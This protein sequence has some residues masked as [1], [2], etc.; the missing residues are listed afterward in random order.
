MSSSPE[1]ITYNPKIEVDDSGEV[2]VIFPSKEE[3]IV[4]FL[5]ASSYLGELNKPFVHPLQWLRYKIMFGGG[6]LFR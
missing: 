5:R 2:T 3:Y 4:E 1:V 6:N